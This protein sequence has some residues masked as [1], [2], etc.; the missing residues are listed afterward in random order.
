VLN[1]KDY[2]IRLH[3]VEYNITATQKQ[4]EIYNMPDNLISRLS[5]GR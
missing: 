3:R 2:T 5:L 4:M 1:R